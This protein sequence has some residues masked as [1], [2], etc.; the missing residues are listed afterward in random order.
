MRSWSTLE[1][2]AFCQVD[3]RTVVRWVTSGA[4]PSWTTAGGRHRVP[5]D[6]LV[7]FLAEHGMAIPPELA[8]QRFVVFGG[9]AEAVRG[10]LHG[11]S[12]DVYTDTFD[13]G[14]A[15]GRARPAA[16]VIDAAHPEGARIAARIAADT[17]LAALDVVVVG[18][19]DVPLTALRSALRRG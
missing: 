3:R 1:V 11:C 14:V 13:L 9:L 19:Q 6:A 12:V 2:A 16:V 17:E 5:H 15:L 7:R 10:A 8:P 4:L 18:P